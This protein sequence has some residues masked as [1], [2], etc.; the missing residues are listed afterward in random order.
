MT[1]PDYLSLARG[2]GKAAFR[3]LAQIFDRLLLAAGALVAGHCRQLI[4]NDVFGILGASA[5]NPVPF[6]GMGMGK[7][8]VGHCDKLLF[9]L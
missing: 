9:G 1:Q 5:V 6:G 4:W 2:T 8:R 7:A 3:C